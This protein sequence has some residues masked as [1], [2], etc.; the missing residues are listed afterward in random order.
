[1]VEL[2]EVARPAEAPAPGDERAAAPISCR[3]G[4]LDLRRNVSRCRLPFVLFRV[5]AWSGTGRLGE[6]LALRVLDQQRQ[7]ALEDLGE[8][9]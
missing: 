3:H 8:I 1:V 6:L 7:G 4:P 5:A 9:P 2:D